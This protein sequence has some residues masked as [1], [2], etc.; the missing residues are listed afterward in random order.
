[1]SPLTPT[2]H[3]AAMKHYCALLEQLRAEQLPKAPH[4]GS[5][6][7]G[8]LGRHDYFDADARFDRALGESRR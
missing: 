6:A 2:T 7:G 4:P 3:H 8:F 5:F 1:M